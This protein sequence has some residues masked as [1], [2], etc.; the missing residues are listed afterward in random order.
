MTPMYPNATRILAE[1]VEIGQRM[2]VGNDTP[3][4]VDV[5]HTGSGVWIETASDPACCGTAEFYLSDAVVRVLP[6]PGPEQAAPSPF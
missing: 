4:V 5:R 3:F 1:D 6:G 2:V